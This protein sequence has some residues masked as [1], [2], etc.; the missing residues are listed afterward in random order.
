[1]SMWKSIYDVGNDPAGERDENL[2]GGFVSYLGDMEIP[3]F[4]HF[5]GQEGD[6]APLS[7]LIEARI[8]RAHSIICREVSP[9]P[10]RL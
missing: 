9:I 3:E 7:G 6:I 2:R 4:R 10:V 5:A 8:R 1:M